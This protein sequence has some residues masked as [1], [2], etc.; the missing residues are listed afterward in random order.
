[1]PPIL[2]LIRLW[3]AYIIPIKQGYLY[4]NYIYLIYWEKL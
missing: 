4:C 3:L 2:P 1:M